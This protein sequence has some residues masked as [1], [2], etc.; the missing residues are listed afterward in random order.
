MSFLIKGSGI[1]N[2]EKR[3]SDLYKKIEEIKNVQI[4]NGYYAEPISDELISNTVPLI[5]WLFDVFAT[6]FLRQI[7]QFK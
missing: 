3:K 1:M 5:L 7:K 6:Y 2:I 4:W